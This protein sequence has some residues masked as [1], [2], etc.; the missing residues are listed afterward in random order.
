MSLFSGV[1]VLLTMIIDLLSC[2][3]SFFDPRHIVVIVIVIVLILPTFLFPALDSTRQRHLRR[4]R[5]CVCS[6]YGFLFIL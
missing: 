4:L 5:R 2:G 1:F 3:T 6:T